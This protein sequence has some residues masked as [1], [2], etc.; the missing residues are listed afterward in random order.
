M[1]LLLDF[2]L[3]SEPGVAV[4]SGWFYNVLQLLLD[5]RNAARAASA[6]VVPTRA[7]APRT[8]ALMRAG[9][10]VWLALL[11][12]PG[13]WSFAGT[14]AA[15]SG[16]LEDLGLPAGRAAFKYF[17][18]P[19]FFA[20]H[21]ADA[22]PRI[23]LRSIAEQDR[24]RHEDPVRE[25]DHESRLLSRFYTSVECP[26]VDARLAPAG[27][28]NL[29]QAGFTLVQSP[30]Q[31]TSDEF[32]DHECVTDTYLPET[33][34]LVKRLTGATRVLAAKYL[35]R[36]RARSDTSGYVA[37]R[38]HVDYTLSSAQQA[39]RQLLCDDGTTTNALLSYRYQ[40]VNVWRRWDGM[41]A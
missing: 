25:R 32:Y 6:S 23:D 35:V 18:R 4:E 33:E 12:A 38:P 28:I 31:M 14:L 20:Q 26:V 3:T 27:A 13:L 36:N 11:L 16:C 2:G 8:G 9:V 21:S 34:D 39:V 40:L 10:R 19:R 41:Y 22:L 7:A 5:V 1:P 17:D 30:T 37:N 24:A 15:A 29:N